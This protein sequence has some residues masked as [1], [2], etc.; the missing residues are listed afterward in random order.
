MF[1]LSMY[2]ARVK[3]VLPYLGDSSDHRE[4]SSIGSPFSRSNAAALLLLSAGVSPH[5][6]SIR[7]HRKYQSAIIRLM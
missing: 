7:V 3:G 4:R 2:I 5:L 6:L 1:F